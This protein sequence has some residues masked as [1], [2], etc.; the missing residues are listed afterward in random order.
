MDSIRNAVKIIDELAYGD[1]T[2]LIISSNETF[3]KIMKKVRSDNFEYRDMVRKK[4][5]TFA[6]M[7]VKHMTKN[8]VRYGLHGISVKRTDV[9]FLPVDL[10]DSA[11]LM[12][13]ARYNNR[14]TIVDTD[15]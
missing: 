2:I 8:Q 6:G 9:V 13:Q 1:A 7:T 4:C 14:A 15:W 5:K 10:D 12:V 3:E 11:R